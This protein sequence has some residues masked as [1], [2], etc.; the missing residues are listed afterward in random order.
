MLL[1]WWKTIDKDLLWLKLRTPVIVFYIGSVALGFVLS[2]S[3]RYSLPPWRG[4][5]QAM[6]ERLKG[7][8]Q[9]PKVTETP[10]SPNSQTVELRKQA[11]DLSQYIDSEPPPD[12]FKEAISLLQSTNR[13]ATIAASQSNLGLVWTGN[14]A[15]AGQIPYQVGIVLHNYV[16]NAARGYQCGGALI[17]PTW[18]LTAGHCFENDSEPNDIA[19]F[20]GPV[21]LSGTPNCS[22]FIDVKRLVRFPGYRQISSAY[23]NILDGDV[24]L[25]ELSHAPTVPMVTPINLTNSTVEGDLLKGSLGTI[26]GWGKS[27]GNTLNDSLMYGTV[28]VTS[29][30]VCDKAYGMGIIKPDMICAHPRPADACQGDSGGPLVMQLTTSAANP[31]Y[32]EGV[33]SWT[34]PPGGCPSTKPTVYS[35]VT[36]F[37]DWINT[38]ISGGTCPSSIG[39]VP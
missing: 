27:T 14:A 13:Q 33:I 17:T 32:V 25:L 2:S 3:L 36:A 5:A 31:S 9:P 15:E 11:D 18:V 35:K 37:S 26:S 10:A 1:R 24:A 22:C 12:S 39:T 29:N 23:G 16:P 34:Y 28:K 4:K 19:V 20:A 7:L 21:K 30:A 6:R 38:C 8:A